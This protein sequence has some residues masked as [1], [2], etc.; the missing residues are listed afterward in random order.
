MM[1]ATIS[2]RLTDRRHKSA[3][4]LVTPKLNIGKLQ[5]YFLRRSYAV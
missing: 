5:R 2:D 3:R 4:F 1:C